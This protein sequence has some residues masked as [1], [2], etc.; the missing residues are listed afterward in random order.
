MRVGFSKDIHVFKNGNFIILGGVKIPCDKSFIAHS[1][2]DVV[3]HSLAEALL[4]S[5]AL[6]DLGKYFPE[7]DPKY[8]NYDSSLIV[9]KCYEMVKKLN[10]RISNIDIS[11]EL[12][13]IKL[14]NYIEEIRKNI[15]KTLDINLDKVSVKAMTNEKQDSTGKGLSCI[16]YCVVCVEEN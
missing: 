2:G 3:F 6:G 7:N 15:A 1:D 5:L 16:S 11:I 14:R 8:D 10:Y 13:N 4:G 9:I 12:E